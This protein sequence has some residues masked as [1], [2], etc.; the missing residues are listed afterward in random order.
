MNSQRNIQKETRARGVLHH[1]KTIK[2]I[3]EIIYKETGCEDCRRGHFCSRDG[4][5]WGCLPYGK[6]AEVLNTDTDHRTQRGG[7]WQ[8][9]TISDQIK[10]RLTKVTPQEKEEWIETQNKKRNEEVIWETIPLNTFGETDLDVDD[11]IERAEL[12]SN[13]EN[14]K[15]VDSF[16]LELKDYLSTKVEKGLE[17]SIILTHRTPKN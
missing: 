12:M 10:K 2:H 11:L 17:L 14:I 16:I 13:V 3:S 1:T 4:K 15:D 6:I 7:L 8:T 5:D 9:K